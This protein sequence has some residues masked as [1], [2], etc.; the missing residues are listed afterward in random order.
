MTFE[1]KDQGLAF[2]QQY[3]NVAWYENGTVRLL[4][5][6]IYPMRVKH[7]VCGSVQAVADAIRD[8]VTQSEGPYAAAAM[9]MA[10]AA[11]HLEGETDPERLKSELRDAAYTLS[12]ARPT[13]S[14]QMEGIVKGSYD[15]LCGLI[16]QGERGAALI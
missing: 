10:L 2:L 3:E 11:H 5:R 6:R 8:M 16:D 9:G 15:R 7:V 1:R 12:H 13:T 4:D 14:A